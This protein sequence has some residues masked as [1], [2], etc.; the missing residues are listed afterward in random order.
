V[1]ERQKYL[2]ELFHFVCL[3]YEKRS[4]V[5]GHLFH[6]NCLFVL[7]TSIEERKRIENENVN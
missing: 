4:S 3:P 1:C 6:P 7:M 2:C 5:Y